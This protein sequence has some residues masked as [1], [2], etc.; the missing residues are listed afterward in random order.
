[1]NER[2]SIIKRNLPQRLDLPRK[3]RSTLYKLEEKIEKSW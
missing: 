3:G 2:D 1:M